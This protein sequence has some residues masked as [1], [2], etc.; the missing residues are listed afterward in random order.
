MS[1]LKCAKKKTLPF[2]NMG[3]TV[4]IAMTHSYP[5][6]KVSGFQVRLTSQIDGNRPVQVHGTQ[7]IVNY[8]TCN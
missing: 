6:P 8:N 2:A 7:G 5:L 4:P 1:Q 3:I